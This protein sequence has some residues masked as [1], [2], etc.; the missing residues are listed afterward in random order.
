MATTKPRHLLSLE[1]DKYAEAYLRSLPPKHFM[2]A[3]GQSIQREITLESLALVRARRPEVQVFN[4]LLVIYPWEEEPKPHLVVP[5][6]MVVIHDQPIKAKGSFK[7]PLQPAGPFW[8]LE[9]VSKESQRKDYDENFQKY[10]RELQVPYYLIFYPDEQELSLYRHMNGKYVSVTANEQGRFALTELDLEL[11]LLEG[12]CRFWYQ[13][14]LLSL[15]GELLHELDTFRQRTQQLEKQLGEANQLA[16]RLQHENQQA[17]Q[18]AEQE[19]QARLALER[20][21]ERLRAK[22]PPE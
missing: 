1:Y 5:D 2:E 11:A 15:P 22:F 16:E 19:R 14:E 12:W 10:E 3:T 7:V 13:G 17:K 20:E 9:Y 18:Q 6:N 21:L 8:M 4:E